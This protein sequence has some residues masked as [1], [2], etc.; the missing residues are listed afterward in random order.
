MAIICSLQED[1]AGSGENLPTSRRKHSSG[2]K[3]IYRVH[4]KIT[5][6]HF[7]IQERT[8]SNNYRLQKLLVF[9]LVRLFRGL[10]L[11]EY[12]YEANLL[13]RLTDCSPASPAM[14]VSSGKSKSQEQEADWVS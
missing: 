1:G 9:G 4:E 13:E 2:F 10:E 8:D 5:V 12:I 11:V 6:N 3:N 7:W 14:A